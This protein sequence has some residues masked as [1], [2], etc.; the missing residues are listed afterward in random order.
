M[1]KGTIKNAI[2]RYKEMAMKK[3][4]WHFKVYCWNGTKDKIFEH[5][6]KI[7]AFQKSETSFTLLRQDTFS[8][9]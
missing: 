9:C 2:F 4:E 1:Y 5:T 8:D 3:G 6:L 7:I